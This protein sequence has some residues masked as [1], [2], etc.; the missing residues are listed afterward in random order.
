MVGTFGL[1]EKEIKPRGEGLL[2]MPHA[3]L[4]SSA[5]SSADH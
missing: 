1:D 2:A 3:R 5:M 4:G